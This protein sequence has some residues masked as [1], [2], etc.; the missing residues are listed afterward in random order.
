MSY[1]PVNYSF[2]SFHDF[3]Y[4]TLVDEKIK[5]SLEIEQDQD[6]TAD[7]KTQEIVNKILTHPSTKNLWDE[8]RRLHS[9]CQITI[10]R[11]S[12]DSA[13]N[14]TGACFRSHTSYIQTQDHTY[15]ILKNPKIFYC[16]A[17]NQDKELYRILFELY[18]LSNS[19]RCFELDEMTTQKKISLEEY[20]ERV[21]QEEGMVAIRAR[22]LYKI[23]LADHCVTERKPWKFWSDKM[24]DAWTQHVSQK[25]NM[26]ETCSKT[27]DEII[28]TQSRFYY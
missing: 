13:K 2:I 9:G 28:S 17:Q 1:N 7:V 25:Y 24:A 23:L 14:P 20:K 4:P 27:P 16:T 22:S 8:V 19:I 15:Y 11:D 26:L 6:I 10:A 21:K 3:P 18:N 12:L 5:S